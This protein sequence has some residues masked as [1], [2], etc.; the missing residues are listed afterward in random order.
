MYILQRRWRYKSWTILRGDIVSIKP[1]D[2]NV[3]LP[4]TQ[5]ISTTKHIEHFK[6]QNIVDSGFIQQEKKTNNNNKKVRDTEKSNN[7][8]IN[9]NNKNRNQKDS[10]KRKK[11]KDNKTSNEDLVP[12]NKGNNIDIRI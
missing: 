8:K 2:F 3:M 11:E 12:S 7:T 10:K 6:N 5:E 9:D 1:I 4:K